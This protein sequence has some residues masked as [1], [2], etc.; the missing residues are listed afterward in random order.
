MH[1]NSLSPE[2]AFLIGLSIVDI[3]I[4]VLPV[5]LPVGFHIRIRHAKLID[6]LHRLLLRTPYWGH[7]NDHY[8]FHVA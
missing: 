1:F 7:D 4:D 5:S 8:T 2:A 3:Q 6:S